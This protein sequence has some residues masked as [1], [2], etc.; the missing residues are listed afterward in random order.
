MDKNNTAS[1]LHSMVGASSNS[2][3]IVFWHHTKWESQG[4]SPT[5]AEPILCKVTNWDL[6]VLTKMG[7]EV[8]VSLRRTEAWENRL[9]KE[10]RREKWLGLGYKTSLDCCCFL[11]GTS[12]REPEA[13]VRGKLR[14]YCCY[15]TGRSRSYSLLFFWF[16][17]VAYF[18]RRV[19]VRLRCMFS[20]VSL[21]WVVLLSDKLSPSINELLSIL[22][23]FAFAHGSS[24]ADSRTQNNL[25]AVHFRPLLCFSPRSLSS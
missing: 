18:G 1:S 3:I 15:D 19:W 20:C 17:L 14:G 8:Y 2:Y 21:S 16:V 22:L 7:W 6:W 24:S 25:E 4:A 10:I 5:P 12:L 9:E 13:L 11:H 23:S